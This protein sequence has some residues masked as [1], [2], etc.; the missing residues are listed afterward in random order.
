MGDSHI[1]PKGK[2][3]RRERVARL[4]LDYRHNPA[5]DKILDED[6][7]GYAKQYRLGRSTFAKRLV[8]E[9]GYERVALAVNSQDGGTGA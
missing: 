4:A 2:T 8:A 5:L 9:L 3:L 7:I 6:R 1:Q